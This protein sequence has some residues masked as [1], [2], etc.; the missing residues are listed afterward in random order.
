MQISR[1]PMFNEC[2]TFNGILNSGKGI[3]SNVLT[4]RLE[5][6]ESVGIINKREHAMVARCYE[7]QPT[8]KGIDLAPVLA[9]MVL[10]SARQDQTDA[11]PKIGRRMTMQRTK[12]LPDVR[13]SRNSTNVDSG[14]KMT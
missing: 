6:L 14:K 10:W 7:Y 5:K 13:I 9:Q 3:A 8:G 1:D 11:P 2:R 12:V 4:D